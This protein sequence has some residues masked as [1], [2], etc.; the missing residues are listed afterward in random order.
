MVERSNEEI[1]AAV[2]ELMRLNSDKEVRRRAEMYEIIEL[3]ARSARN[4]MLKKGIEK[5]KKQEKIE[6]AN[7][8]LELDTSIEDIIKITGLTKEE[9]LEIKN[10]N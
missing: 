5:G 1:E 8:L 6:I 10:K 7:K 4:Y 9:V 2:E 3:N